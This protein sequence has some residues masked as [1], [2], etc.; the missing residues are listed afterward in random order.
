MPFL[1]YWGFVLFWGAW[2][3][4]GGKAAWRSTGHGRVQ[5]QWWYP[6]NHWSIYHSYLLLVWSR[7]MATWLALCRNNK[8]LLLVVYLALVVSSSA[9]SKPSSREHRHI[10]TITSHHS[11][12]FWFACRLAWSI[13]YLLLLLL[14]LELVFVNMLLHKWAVQAGC[15]TISL[16]KDMSRSMSKIVLIHKNPYVDPMS[17]PLRELVELISVSKKKR[18]GEGKG[19]CKM[20]YLVIRR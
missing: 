18:E 20:D 15:R 13:F 7:G 1:H 5:L 3:V 4:G 12:S 14:F 11:M 8:R 10:E 2:L 19:S 6:E 17:I 16:V 9:L